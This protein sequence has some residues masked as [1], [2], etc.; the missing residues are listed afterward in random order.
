M[1][2]PMLFTVCGVYRL[3]VLGMSD[4]VSCEY[5]IILGFF[6]VSSTEVCEETSRKNA[7]LEHLQ[8]RGWRIISKSAWEKSN[9]KL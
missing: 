2:I 1:D 3:H 5:T 8:T 4:I 7:H 6:F 9:V